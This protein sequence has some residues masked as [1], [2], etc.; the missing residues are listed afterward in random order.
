VDELQRT[1]PAKAVA[2]RL[3]NVDVAAPDV[4][5][6]IPQRVGKTDLFEPIAGL[7]E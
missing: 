6:T 4:Q 1:Q 5:S 3:L 2:D 7:I